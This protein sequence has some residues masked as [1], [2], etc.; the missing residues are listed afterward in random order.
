MPGGWVLQDETV[1]NT[2]HSTIFHGSDIGLAAWPERFEV[3][4]QN[5]TPVTT[6][7]PDQ[8]WYVS[9]GAIHGAPADPSD[10]INVIWVDYEQQ[11]SPP[12]TP[13]GDGQNYQWNGIGNTTP[14]DSGG[15]DHY[16]I[17]WDL[18]EFQISLN[19]TG[20]TPTGYGIEVTCRVY[21]WQDNFDDYDNLPT[22]SGDPEDPGYLYPPDSV[23]AIAGEE[24]A[25][26]VSLEWV[27][28]HEGHTGFAIFD[29]SDPE[30]PSPVA[31][32]PLED[33][34]EYAFTEQFARSIAQNYAVTAYNDDKKSVLTTDELPAI[35][36]TMTPHP[37]YMIPGTAGESYSGTF[38][39]D[40]SPEDPEDYT[41]TVFSGTLPTGLSL[42]SDTGVL[43]GTP[44]VASVFWNFVIRAHQADS[45]DPTG[46]GYV[47][48]QAY[49]LQIGAAPESW[50][51][52]PPSGNTK[53]GQ[54]LTITG[55]GVDGEPGEEP[56]FLITDPDGNVHPWNGEVPYPPTDEC[57]DCYDDCPQCNDC[58]TICAEDVN[59]TACQECMQEC[60]DCLTECL[61]EL[62]A[63]EACQAASPGPTITVI[64]GTTFGGTVPLGTLTILTANASG[65]Y[66]FVF[67][68]TNDTIYTPARDGTTYDVKIP[69]PGAK[70]AFFRS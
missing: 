17:A 3:I 1:Y 40:G 70:T 14:P 43:S 42:N 66:T 64:G 20:F 49:N 39:A 36:L 65:I 63:A 24:D 56:T 9:F 23:T 54:T 34:R 15:Y 46:N 18:A 59:S 69:N 4:A 60:L 47:I 7:P 68:K 28:D 11:Q 25:R 55:P 48:L 38:I 58:A 57:L 45:L 16:T 6:V 12:G 62:E 30:Y 35:V 10:G 67:G 50:T 53:P 37:G 5:T 22:E 61:E 41:Y 52:S 21:A 13:V 27:Y 19:G 51:L 32:V 44:S 33:A 2:T 8:E 29:V 26:Y 31:L